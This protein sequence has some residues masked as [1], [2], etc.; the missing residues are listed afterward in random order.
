MIDTFDISELDMTDFPFVG[1]FYT[2]EVDEEAPLDERVPQEVVIFETPCD[3]QRRG[4]LGG[5]GMLAA[6]YVVF[7]PLEENPDSDCT[8]DKY[9]PVLVRRGM[10]FRG[11]CYGYTAEGVVEFVRVSQLGGCSVDIKITTESDI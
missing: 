10:R 7:F 9:G 5:S 4:K 11:E 1:E 3:I 8:A 6:D 2:Y